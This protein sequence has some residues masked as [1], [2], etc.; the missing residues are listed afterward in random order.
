MGKGYEIIASGKNVLIKGVCNIT[1]QGDSVLNVQGDAYTQIDGNAYENI[2]GNVKQ[3]VQGDSRL[4]VDGDVDIDSS[5]DINLGASTVNI[6]AD[7]MVRGDIGCSQSI[8]A[9]GN[10]TAKISLSA[11]KSVETLGYMV[12]GT[13]I[14]AG[15]SVFG[16]MV[17]DMFG[18]MEMFRMK[19]NQHVHIGNKGFP[20]SP[21]TTPMET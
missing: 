21:P 1:V 19:V 14:D 4:I 12:A 15:V 18:S 5:G 10:I 7:L 20:T 6:N 13:T 16:P 3:V 2:K 9:D 11:T 17:S 8:Q